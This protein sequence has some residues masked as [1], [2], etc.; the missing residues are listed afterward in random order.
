MRGRG[1][2]AAVLSPSR[3]LAGKQM[4]ATIK[5]QSMMQFRLVCSSL[6]C[7]FLHFHAVA[8]G[9]LSWPYIWSGDLNR[10]IK[11]NVSPR[12]RHQSLRF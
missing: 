3:V 9:T 4:A 5:T 11:L 7:R 2:D 8:P 10:I 6:T 12:E 1:R